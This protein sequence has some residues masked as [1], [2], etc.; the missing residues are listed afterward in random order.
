MEIYE[1]FHASQK[2]HVLNLPRQKHHDS[3]NEHRHGEDNNRHDVLLNRNRVIDESNYGGKDE[4]AQR[5]KDPLMTNIAPAD[6]CLSC[7]NDDGDVQQHVN[8]DWK[9]LGDDSEGDVEIK[10]EWHFIELVAA[11]GSED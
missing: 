8:H 6:R 7:R 3:T 9:Q 4:N 10:L 1:N 2:T 11:D 5:I